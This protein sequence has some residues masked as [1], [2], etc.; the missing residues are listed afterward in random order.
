[1]GRMLSVNHEKKFAPRP[2]FLSLVLFLADNPTKSWSLRINQSG[3]ND[4]NEIRII[5]ICR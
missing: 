5:S 4:V 1:M 3:D 2:V